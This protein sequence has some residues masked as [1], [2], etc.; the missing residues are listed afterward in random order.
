M[1]RLPYIGLDMPL[2][3]LTGAGSQ[4]LE[5]FD[6][7]EVDVSSAN[8]THKYVF[9]NG[10]RDC[11]F[12]PPSTGP[13]QAS[14][15]NTEATAWQPLRFFPDLSNY[16]FEGSELVGGTMCQKFTFNAKH[17]TKGTM[18]DHMSFYWD[19]VLGKPVRWHMHAR[20]VTFGSH[21]DEYIMEFLSFQAGEPAEKE[22]ALPERCEKPSRGSVSI[23]IGGLLRAAY[24]H[25]PLSH[26]ETSHLH[27]GTFLK[28]YGKS[29]SPKEHASRHEIFVN[30]VNRIEELNKQ[31]KGTA[32]FRGN[33]FL[34]MT[35]E[36]VLLFRG[37][38]SRGRT[39][40]QRQSAEHLKLIHEFS[41]GTMTNTP[42]SF[43]WRTA[44]P[45]VVGP[46]KDQGMCGSCWTYGAMGPIE[47]MHAI[48][49]G[50][51]VELPEQFMLDCTWINGTGESGG[52][53]GCDGGDSDIG[54]LEIVKKFGG[55]IP[56]ASAYGS[57]L[58]V[59]GYCKDTRRMDVGAK[60]TG[61]VNVKARDEEGLLSALVTKGPISVGI[62]VPPEMLYYDSGVLNVESCRHN[63]SQ[64]DHAVVLV[65]YGTENGTKYY[66]I[67]NSWST[68][69]GD[70][71]YIKIAR[72]DLD[73]AVSSEAGF[74]KIAAT[75]QADVIV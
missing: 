73:C 21:T 31:S 33:Q 51:L 74:P 10:H 44:R 38:K 40:K 36:E 5:Y 23:H 4:K 14:R 64:I 43:D 9:N 30:N 58:S 69:W 19:P 18:D 49:T 70:Q 56:T 17:G 39:R 65:G 54:A 25:Q 11:L 24:A 37:G 3:V 57:Y 16:V 32:T 29:Y 50:D 12:T 2:R 63:E 72:G 27:Y 28:K 13:T 66:T 60:I 59:D 7:L 53:F 45:G 35:M 71:G 34:D 41:V 75:T 62:M 1:L 42:E 55:V 15:G 8:G 61:W 52:N 6:G 47:T 48:Q 68:Y 46:V 22:L 26:D 20:H 67:R